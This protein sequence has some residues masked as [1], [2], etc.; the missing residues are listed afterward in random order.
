V[1][2][3]PY[4]DSGRRLQSQWLCE[5]AFDGGR[6]TTRPSPPTTDKLV[7]SISTDDFDTILSTRLPKS[8][9]SPTGRGG[10]R[11]T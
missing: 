9:Q 5:L 6:R 8:R 1:P 11:S 4:R 7:L 3:D 10:T 2:R